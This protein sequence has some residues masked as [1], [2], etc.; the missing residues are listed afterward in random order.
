[1]RVSVCPCDTVDSAANGPEGSARSARM[2]VTTAGTVNLERFSSV[3]ENITDEE[4]A[5]PVV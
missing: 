3:F 2:S 1:M 4:V 5:D